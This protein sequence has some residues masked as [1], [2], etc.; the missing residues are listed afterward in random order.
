MPQPTRR[1]N[2]RLESRSIGLGCENRVLSIPHMINPTAP[3]STAPTKALEVLILVWFVT[4]CSTCHRVSCELRP[5]ETMNAGAAKEMP[6]DRS[7]VV[8]A[9]CLGE[10]TDWWI[11]TGDTAPPM[12][13]ETMR[14]DPVRVI[15]GDR[16]HIVDASHHGAGRAWWVET[17]DTAPPIA[18][19][20]MRP[21]P[22]EVKAGDRSRVVDAD[23]P[24][25]SSAW[26]VETR[27]TA[28]P[29]AEETMNNAPSVG[30]SS[31][32]GS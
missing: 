15:P 13:N 25:H 7:C 26:C 6:G 23:Y 30:V 5:N 11:K 19:E 29:I 27:E 24:G 21:G 17:G 12:A 9:E 31:C 32:D 4:D 16:S 8:D 18:N 2:R 3:N 10:G 14:A 1:P 28:P 22:A 20:T